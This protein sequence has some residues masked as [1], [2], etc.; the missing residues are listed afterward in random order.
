MISTLD[1]SEPP[2]LAGVPQYSIIIP[3]VGD[4]FNALFS[5]INI[6]TSMNK[7]DSKIIVFGTTAHM[8]AL[9]AELFQ[10]QSN[11]KVYELHSRLSQPQRTQATSQFKDAKRGIMFATD[12]IRTVLQYFPRIR[13]SNDGSS[14]RSRHG[15]S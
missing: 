13:G 6:E 11:L 4:T 1:A 14:Y 9:Y 5:T 12:G 8:V 15:F 3:R 2:T 10:G 7:D